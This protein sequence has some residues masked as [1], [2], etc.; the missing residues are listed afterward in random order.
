MADLQESILRMLNIC[1]DT[2]EIPEMIQTVNVAMV[3]KPGKKSNHDLENQRVPDQHFSKYPH[4]T[5]FK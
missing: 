2:L 1:K 3:P 4:E 5:N